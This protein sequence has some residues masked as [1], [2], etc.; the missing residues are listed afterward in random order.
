MCE[1]GWKNQLKNADWK[2]SKISEV[3]RKN[4]C[5]IENYVSGG[6]TM[7][8]KGKTAIVTGG[9]RGIGYATVE[10]F[11]KEGAKVILCLQRRN[12]SK[13]GCLTERKVSRCCGGFHD[14]E[15]E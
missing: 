13:G 14:T 7:L 1:C 6:V 11:L 2:I 10:A 15:S 12:G 8:L 3:S 9:S 4:L 5:N